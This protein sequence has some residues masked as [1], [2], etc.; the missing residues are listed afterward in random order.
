MKF[1]SFW[2]QKGVDQVLPESN[3]IVVLVSH[4]AD[5]MADP[6]QTWGFWWLRKGLLLLPRCKS[7]GQS[8]K[9]ADNC[10]DN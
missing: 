1:S 2:F 7:Q 10:H 3:I 8:T 4:E 6:R 5:D 9:D